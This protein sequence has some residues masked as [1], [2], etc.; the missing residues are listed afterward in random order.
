M[1][2]WRKIEREIRRKKQQRKICKDIENME[3]ES[4]DF[5]PQIYS[6]YAIH[7]KNIRFCSNT[8][9]Y[10]PAGMVFFAIFGC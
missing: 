1:Q 8:Y 3:E 10:N 7:K 5:I 4:L 6:L 2:E 9:R